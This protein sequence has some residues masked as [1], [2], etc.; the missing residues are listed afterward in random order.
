MPYRLISS[1]LLL[2]SLTACSSLKPPPT[3][4][5]SP[6]A[7]RGRAVFDLYCSRCHGR[8]GDT[9]IVGPSLAGI[10]TRGNGRVEGM[11]ARTYILNS[12]LD[13]RAYTVE[14]F[15]EGVMPPDLKNQLSPEDLEAVVAYLLTLE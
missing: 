10:A 2:L 9:V 1:L 7:V 11:D 6:Q 12:I 4:T 5:P 3:P 13:P 14:G 8:S 15:P